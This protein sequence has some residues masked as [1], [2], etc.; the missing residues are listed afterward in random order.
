[1]QYFTKNGMYSVFPNVSLRT[2]IFRSV[3]DTGNIFHRT[4]N[5]VRRQTFYLK[6]QLINLTNIW[7]RTVYTS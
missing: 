4:K 7:K 5:Q 1:M 2:L 6:N 3:K